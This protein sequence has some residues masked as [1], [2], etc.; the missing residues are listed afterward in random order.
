MASALFMRVSY[1]A[2]RPTVELGEALA[3]AVGDACAAFNLPS[4]LAAWVRVELELRL[5]GSVVLRRVSGAMDVA[6]VVVVAP[7]LALLP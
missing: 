2:M 4:S 5:R 1:A 7:A 6:R 3:R